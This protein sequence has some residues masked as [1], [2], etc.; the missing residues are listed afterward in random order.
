LPRQCLARLIGESL[1]CPATQR[2]DQMQVLPTSTSAVPAAIVAKKRNAIIRAF[3]ESGATHPDAARTLQEVGL[4]PTLLAE[5]LKLRHVLVEVDGSRFY[6]DT[7]REEEI[8]RTRGVIIA[9]LV[10]ALVVVL[11]VLWRTGGL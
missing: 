11:F 5:V 8:T 9:L 7:R 1:G 2:G 10:L 4:P 6:L 3:R